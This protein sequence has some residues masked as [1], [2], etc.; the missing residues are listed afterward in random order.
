ML[1]EIGYEQWLE[2]G[3]VYCVRPNEGEGSTCPTVV[4]VSGGELYFTNWSVDV[5]AKGV[6]TAQREMLAGGIS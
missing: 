4:E 1:V 6:R 3:L 5:V 2:A